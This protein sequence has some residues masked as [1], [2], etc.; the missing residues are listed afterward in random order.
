MM[1]L[2]EPIAAERIWPTLLWRTFQMHIFNE[3][4]NSLIQIL[5]TVFLFLVLNKQ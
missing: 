4:V 3:I 5:L 1:A 2:Q